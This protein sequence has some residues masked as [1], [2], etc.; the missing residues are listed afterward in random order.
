MFGNKLEAWRLNLFH[1]FQ[2][3]QSGMVFEIENHFP[4]RFNAISSGKS[5]LISVPFLTCELDVLQSGMV[6]EIVNHFPCRF[7]A[8]SSE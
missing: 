1:I 5:C 3:L 8:I 6:F 7:N 4:C 2:F